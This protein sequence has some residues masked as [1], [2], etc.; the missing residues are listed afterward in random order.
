M[1]DIGPLA[2]LI[3]SVDKLELM[4]SECVLAPT[5]FPHGSGEEWRKDR[6][7]HSSQPPGREIP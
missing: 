3:L 5:L 1:Y 6:D 7:K 2:N 4:S